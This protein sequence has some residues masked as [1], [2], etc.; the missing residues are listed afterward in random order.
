MST[1]R[2]SW[3]L[4]YTSRC[5]GDAVR[6]SAI[7]Y[8]MASSSAVMAPAKMEPAASRDFC[9]SFLHPRFTLKRQP[10]NMAALLTIP[11]S[12]S[13]SITWQAKTLMEASNFLFNF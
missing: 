2:H 5:V 9:H 13:V 8:L 3:K 10:T 7:P 11:P 4:L 6:I 12:F 1:F